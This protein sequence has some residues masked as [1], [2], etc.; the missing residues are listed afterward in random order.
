MS[1]SSNRIAAV[2]GLRALAVF[3]VVW[4]HVWSFGCGAPSW[5]VGKIGTLNLDLN[6]AISMIGTGV[7]L[8]FVIS[9]FCMYLV[10]ASKQTKF[11]WSA[12]GIFLKSRWLRIAPAFYV[13]ASVCA[14]FVALFGSPF[15]YISLVQHITFVHTWFGSQDLAA[16]FWS[17]AT[18]WHFY[19]VL[20]LLI[21]FSNYLGFWKTAIALMTLSIGFRFWVYTS[22][23]NIQAF[24]V[25]QLPSR[26]VEFILGLCV[27]KLYISKTAP[28]KLLQ[29]EI[30][31]VGATSVAYLGRVLMLSEVVKIM[32]PAGYIF[33]VMAE[34]V[35][36]LGY[37]LILW[38][39]ISSKSIFQKLLSHQMLQQLGVYS[40]SLYLW[41]WYPSI[42]IAQWF[43]TK[44]GK[45][46]LVQNVALL[47]SLILLIP[48]SFISYHL[49]ETPY[50]RKKTLSK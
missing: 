10:Y 40:Y 1:S 11:T 36:S 26:L 44:F 22:S 6:R 32:G 50:F 30:G 13:C 9:G 23:D 24:W 17:L 4:A 39:V 3:G 14:I 34:P 27:A 2:D 18:E 43:V 37:S 41:H 15:P 29:N 5:S 31:F 42:W 8:F 16:P 46:I 38:N 7:D 21:W 20:P 49:L 12:Y 19:L 28:P 45:T 48:L 25:N 35:L 33:K 47:V